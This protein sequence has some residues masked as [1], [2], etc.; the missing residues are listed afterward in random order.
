MPPPPFPSPRRGAAGT[1]EAGELVA[2]APQLRLRAAVGGNAEPMQFRCDACEYAYELD[3]QL[4][5]P[6]RLDR[7]VIDDIISL[8]DVMKNAPQTKGAVTAADPRTQLAMRV[9]RR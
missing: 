6:A 3:Q 7:K 2:Q 5:K 1:R 9:L 4:R 8:E